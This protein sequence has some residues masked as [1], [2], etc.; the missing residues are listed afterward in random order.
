MLQLGIAWV[1]ARFIDRAVSNQPPPPSAL[2]KRFR[3]G[4]WPL[5]PA[6]IITWA[7][8][9]VFLGLDRSQ[10]TW[11]GISTLLGCVAV[12]A[13]SVRVGPADQS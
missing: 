1:M 7:L 4:L 11:T 9:G 5:I 12:V 13:T 10:W 8:N 3:L 6:F 2:G